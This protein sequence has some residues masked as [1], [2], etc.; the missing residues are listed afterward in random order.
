MNAPVMSRRVPAIEALADRYS[1]FLFDQFG[2][3]HDGTRAY[4]GCSETLAALRAAD[5]RIGVITNSGKRAV[6][7]RTRLAGFGFDETLIDIVVSSGEVAWSW[8]SGSNDGLA[9]SSLPRSPLPSRSASARA[10]E[11]GAGLRV[12]VVARGDDRGFV[13]QLPL[14]ESDEAET[15]ELVLI[16]GCEPEKLTLDDYRERLAP[17]AR[18]EVPALC[19]NPDQVMLLGEGRTGFAAGAVADA[20]AALGG[21]VTRIGK[22]FPAIYAHALALAGVTPAETLCIGDSVEHDVAGARAAGCHSLLVRTGI[23]AGATDTE[24]ER[25]FVTEGHR[26]TWIVDDRKLG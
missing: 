3:L 2:V 21:P 13:E 11:A 17:A 23:H 8:L 19:T 25:L 24:L 9:S 14:V 4:P 1:L 5:R 12:L 26:P 20:Y 7:N 18:R 22:P 15:C 16:A 10:V 6:Y